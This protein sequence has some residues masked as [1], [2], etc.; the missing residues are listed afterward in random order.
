MSKHVAKVLLFNSAQQVLILR[1]SETHPYF[2]HETDYP[3]GEIEHGETGLDGVQ[4]EL[5]EE[6]GISIPLEHFQLVHMKHYKFL[7]RKHYVY[8]VDLGDE[9]PD[10]AISWEHESYHWVHPHELLNDP[11]WQGKDSYIG[12]VNEYLAK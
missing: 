4:R 2:P 11:I 8:R 7:G 10:V 3:G 9:A 5:V 12:L 6:T 1:R